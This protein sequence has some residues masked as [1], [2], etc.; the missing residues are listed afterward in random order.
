MTGKRLEIVVDLDLCDSHGVCVSHAPDVFQIGDD[1]RMRILVRHPSEAQL[2]QVRA[3]VR[4]CPKGALS[5][6]DAE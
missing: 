1:D 5:L 4:G 2:A 6:V 3:A